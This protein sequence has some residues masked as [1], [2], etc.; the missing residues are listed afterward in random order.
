MQHHTATVSCLGDGIHRSKDLDNWPAV[1]GASRFASRS[2]PTSTARSGRSRSRSISS[3]AKV[4]LCGYLQNSP[5]P[6]GAVEV[7]ER[8]G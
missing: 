5:D 6:F 7:G 4:R 3:S 2:V 8:E 1:R